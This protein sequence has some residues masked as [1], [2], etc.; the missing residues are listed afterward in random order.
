MTEQKEYS[1]WIRSVF[2]VS[3]KADSQG[4]AMQEVFRALD[5]SN[6]DYKLKSEAT[7]DRE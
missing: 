5:N 6:Y 4:E 7:I 3:V 2:K 1:F